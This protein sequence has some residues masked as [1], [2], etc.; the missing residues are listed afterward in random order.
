MPDTNR[1]DLDPWN[2]ANWE[3]VAG[4]ANTCDAALIVSFPALALF[5]LQKGLRVIHLDTLWWMWPAVTQELFKPFGLGQF[6]Q[7]IPPFL[8]TYTRGLENLHNA[9]LVDELTPEEDDDAELELDEGSMLIAFGGMGAAGNPNAADAYARF[10]TGV[11]LAAVEISDIEVADVEIVG[12]S[13]SFIQWCQLLKKEHSALPISA[14]QALSRQQYLTK[15]RSSR[16]LVLT[17]GLA[18]IRECSRYRLRPL[19]QPGDNKSM[20]LQLAALQQISG[21][22]CLTWSWSPEVV[23]L[24]D[25]VRE[26]ILLREISDRIDCEISAR[27]SVPRFQKQLETHLRRPAV[28]VLPLEE[29]RPSCSSILADVLQDTPA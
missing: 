27:S 9:I 7:L 19:F 4:L 1:V 11:C 28:L 15:L 23:A 8:P 3:S 12:G 2:R 5:L 21:A 17:P 24:K 26:E 25:S 10:I 6:C 22:A 14:V 20:I 29:K 18:T 13:A 16:S